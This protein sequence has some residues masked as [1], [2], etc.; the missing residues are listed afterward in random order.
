LEVEDLDTALTHPSDE[1]VV[2]VLRALDPEDVVE[3]ELVVVRRCEAAEAEVR[4]M[5][6]DLSE[7]PDL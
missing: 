1:L 3:Q 7:L 5:D 6:H 2:L 4:T